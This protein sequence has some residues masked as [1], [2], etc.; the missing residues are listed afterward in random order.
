VG[1]VAVIAAVGITYAV[2]GG[3]SSTSK[4]A[5]AVFS[6]VQARTL[7]DTVTLSGT[8]SRKSIRNVNA[9]GQ[10]LVSSVTAS[11]G[12]IAKAQQTLFA[13]GGRSAVTEPGT[14]P[15]FRSLAP[16]SRGP[17][18]LEL[19]RILAASGNFPGPMDDFFSQQTQFALAQWQSQHGYPNASPSNQQAVTV[20][21]VQGV[22]YQLGAQDSAPLIIG[23]PTPKTSALHT[24]SGTHHVSLV[25]VE[26]HVAQPILTIQSTSGRVTQGM[27]A[28]FVVSASESSASPTTVSLIT[29]GTATSQDIVTPP[30]QVVLPAGATQVGV[31]VQTRSTTTVSAD[32][33]I[34]ESIGAGAGYVVGTPASASTAIANSNLP[35]LTLTGGSTVSPGGTATLTVTADQ[36]PLQAIQ[37]VVGVTGSAQPGTDYNPVNPVINLCAGCT[38]ATVSISTL[39]T[40]VIQPDK[41]IVASLQPSPGSYSVGSPGTAVVTLA[42]SH[43]QPTVTIT[44]ASTYLQKGQPYAVSIGLNQAVSTPTTI[45]LSYGGTAVQGTDYNQP[46]GT[47]IVPAGQ[48]STQVAIPTVTSNTVQ[49]DRTLSV[50]VAS[51]GSYQV[52][53]PST[54]ST[55]ITSS[56]LPVLT[57]SSSAPSVVQ[58]GSATFTITASQA[59]V[60]DTTVSFAVQGTVQAGQG[61]VPLAGAALLPAGQ[62]KVSVVLQSIQTDVTFQPTDMIVGQWPTRI[63]QVNVKA[64]QAVAPGQAILSLVEPDL[65]VTLQASAADRTKLAVGQR[66]KVQINGANDEGTGVITELDSDTTQVG[67]TQVY[68]GQ[69]ALTGLTGADGSQ[70]SI[71]VIDRQ[72]DDALTVPIAAVKQQGSGA[73]VV[74]V[75][76]LKHGGRITEVPVTTGMTE[77]SYIQISEGLRLGQV[78]LVQVTPPS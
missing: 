55:T 50:S 20:S 70:V 60:K 71:T 41:Y 14:L 31:T 40:T 44:A 74:R 9:T 24:G 66:C 46:A 53:N 15:F 19:K 26:P 38:T 23:P 75:V 37:V 25:S 10:A 4:D 39:S 43:A 73:N 27:P 17:D 34:T 76:D 12:D 54:V 33:V 22:G 67:T 72:I 42:G 36:A 56:V 6:R 1:I 28:N 8:L 47:I 52:G 58:G 21:L 65:S 61:Y 29:G 59:P 51:S 63:G 49:S 7:Q 48:T 30:V 68:E 57:I 3:S 13:L 69:I 11:A 16:G 62:T 2:A 35:Q 45:Q 78:V 64:G 77:G 18:V 32:P 5:V